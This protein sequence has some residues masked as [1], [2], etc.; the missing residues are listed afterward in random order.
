MARAVLVII[1]LISDFPLKSKFHARRLS[2]KRYLSSLY[3]TWWNVS[4][5][6]YRLIYEY[7]KANFLWGVFILI[8]ICHLC[9]KK[10][11]YPQKKGENIIERISNNW[12]DLFIMTQR[13]QNIIKIIN[14]F[15]EW[16]SFFA[17]RHFIFASKHALSF[18]VWTRLLWMILAENKIL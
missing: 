6:I 10:A 7:L 15:C 4:Y 17:L 13:V 14:Q 11:G 3:I 12:P 18:M 16:K 8:S 5:P 1:F 9:P 2:F